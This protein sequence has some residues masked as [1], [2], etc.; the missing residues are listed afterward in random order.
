MCTA[1]PLLLVAAPFILSVAVSPPA[2]TEER[3]ARVH[4]QAECEVWA[5]ELAFADAVARHDVAAFAEHVHPQAVF[6]AGAPQP[7]RGRD[8]IVDA[9]ADIIAGRG[10]RLSWYPA[11][12]AIGGADDVAWS[13]G[14]ALFERT[15]A[16]AGG[17]YALRSFHSVW[18]RGADGVWRVLFDQGAGPPVPA[19]AAAVEAF[20]AARRVPCPR[21]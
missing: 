9:W 2:A 5:R 12:V 6:D 10:L 1:R 18:H 21:G 3:P 19:D 16:D 11:R 14:P 20:R 13:S 17:R 15:A 8:A 7:L 4:S